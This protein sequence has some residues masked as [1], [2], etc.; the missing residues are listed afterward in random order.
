MAAQRHP[1]TVADPGGATLFSADLN[2]AE[3]GSVT[4]SWVRFLGMYEPKHLYARKFSATGEALWGEADPSGGRRPLA[5]F[6][7][8]TLQMANFRPF[9][10]DGKG[11]AVFAWYEV[12]PLQTRAQWIHADGTAVFPANGMAVEY[13]LA[14]EQVEPAAAFNPTTEAIYLFWRQPYH[15]GGLYRQPVFGQKLTAAGGREW[16]PDGMEGEPRHLPW[17]PARPAWRRWWAAPTASS[18]AGPT[19]GRTSPTST[20]N[21][22][23]LTA[24]LAFPG[25]RPRACH[26]PG[27]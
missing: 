5:V 2:A 18:S 15:F 10:S 20:R 14:W 21:A 1:L 26:C 19:A 4:L 11:G 13:N 22:S 9:V 8:D 17:H 23:T 24:Q 12:E 27:C 6:A 7:D 16:G 25:R 3:G